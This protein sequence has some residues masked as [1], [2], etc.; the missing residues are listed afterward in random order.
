MSYTKPVERPVRDVG[1]ELVQ[2]I[3]QHN[4]LHPPR[5]RVVESPLLEP[6]RMHRAGLFP[7]HC[8]P[9]EPIHLMQVD[10]MQAFD[11]KKDEIGRCCFQT[12]EMGCAITS[13]MVAVLPV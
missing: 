2:F 9:R 3:H 5:T 1:H 7:L 10:T 13:A 11:L 8:L 12:P 4:T 6:E